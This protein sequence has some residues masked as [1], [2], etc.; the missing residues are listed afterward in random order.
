MTAIDVESKFEQKIRQAG[1]VPFFSADES[2]FL[3]TEGD[4][5]AEIVARDSTK[6]PEFGRIAEEVKAENPSVKTVVRA[7]WEVEGVGDPMPAY[8]MQTG[9][10]R[11]AVLYPV[12]LKS[13]SG[14]QQIW[15]EV[16]TLASWALEEHGFD[17][18]AIKRVVRDFVVKQ[19]KIG[20]SSYWDPIR[21]P[22]LEISGDTAEYIVSKTSAKQ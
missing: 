9:T 7:H 13:G 3:D 2:H 16:T 4:L 11:M 20:G 18:E 22:R 15:V 14:K 5:F 12:V 6:L 10:P 17:S 8:D 19:L 21:S 1:L